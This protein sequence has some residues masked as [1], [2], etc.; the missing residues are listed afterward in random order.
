MD[1]LG[2]DLGGVIITRAQSDGDTSFF[3][4][5]YLKTP[6]VDDAIEII[7]ELKQRR[8][9]DHVY[10]VSK[11]GPE[12]ERKSREWLDYLAFYNMSGISREHI[13]FC[14]TRPEK[15]PI[16]EMLGVNCFIDDRIDVLSHMKSVTTR[17]LFGAETSHDSNF[18]A[19]PSWKSVKSILLDD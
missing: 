8:Y 1:K 19:A 2:I 15:A 7:R 17:I 10:I 18:V 5:D 4:S 3:T 6:P 12:V 16:C 9:G 13:H 11:C 14:R